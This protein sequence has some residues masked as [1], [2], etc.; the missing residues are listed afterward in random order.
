MKNGEV[1]NTCAG[2]GRYSANRSTF[3]PMDARQRLEAAKAEFGAS[4]KQAGWS[5]RSW[6]RQTE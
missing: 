6:K 1:V 5:E 2:A 4:W 3:A